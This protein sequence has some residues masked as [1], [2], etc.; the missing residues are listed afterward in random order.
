[1]D[2][3]LVS[4]DEGALFGEEEVTGAPMGAVEA[5]VRRALAA[6]LEAMIVGPTDAALAEAAVVAGRALDRANRLPDKSAVYAVAQ[7][8]RPFQDALHALRLP[9]E[10]TPAAVP[11][12]PAE[13]SPSSLGDLLGD[14]LGRPE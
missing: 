9:A 10:V 13:N 6:G 14:A 11:S 4:T 3:G 2:A 1:V 7:L 5:G 12:A 8:M